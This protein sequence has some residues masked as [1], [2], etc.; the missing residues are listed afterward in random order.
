MK[1][2]LLRRVI[3]SRKSN[4]E[5][6]LQKVVETV[7]SLSLQLLDIK[8]KEINETI[9]LFLVL[10]KLNKHYTGTSSRNEQLITWRKLVFRQFM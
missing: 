4:K 2:T 5:S 10:P 6:T 1:G 3:E 8:L 7:L 9:S